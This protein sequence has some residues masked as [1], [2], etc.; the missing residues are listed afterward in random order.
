MRRIGLGCCAS[1]ERSRDYVMNSR[2]LMAVPPEN[3]HYA[4]SQSLPA[5]A[6]KRSLP[7]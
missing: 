1:G 3:A 6:H 7:H 4:Q 2:R 5:F